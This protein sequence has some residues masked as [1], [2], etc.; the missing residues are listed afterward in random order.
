MVHAHEEICRV[1]IEQGNV[2]DLRPLTGSWP[3]EVVSRGQ[4]RAVGYVTGMAEGIA[5][6][7]AANEA[8]AKAAADGLLRREREERFDFCYYWNSPG[9]M[10]EYIDEE[11]ADFV[12]VEADTAKAARRLWAVAEAD[13]RVSVRLSMLITR[14]SKPG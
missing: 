13:A 4:R 12:K 5:D 10:Q 7:T 3:M 14:W 9:E 1:L 8:M 6:D 2:I 11:W